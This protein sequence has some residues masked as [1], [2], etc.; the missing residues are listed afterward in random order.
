MDTG[1]LRS[2]LGQITRNRDLYPVSL[3][4]NYLSYQLIDISVIFQPYNGGTTYLKGSA[5]LK[6]DL[7]SMLNFILNFIFVFSSKQFYCKCIG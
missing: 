3:D 5:Y 7:C 2:N 1:A 6:D 4:I